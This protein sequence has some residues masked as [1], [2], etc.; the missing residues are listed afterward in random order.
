VPRE[1]VLLSVPLYGW[2]W[3]SASD[4][5]G[6]AARGKAR[7]LTFA[8]TPAALMPNDRLVATELAKVHGLRR[9]AEHTPYYAYQEGSNGIKGVR[10]SSRA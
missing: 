10:G 7:L 5:P 4:Q 1:A 6:A 8:E 9:D 2:Q 3:P